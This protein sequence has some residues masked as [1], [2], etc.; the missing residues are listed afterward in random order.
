M[1]SPKQIAID[2]SN[3]DQKA[4]RELERML[5]KSLDEMSNEEKVIGL[6]CLSAF[7]KQWN[8]EAR[9]ELEKEGRV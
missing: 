7:E 6:A 5:G 9:E 3:G 8:G 4:K 2:I 1:R